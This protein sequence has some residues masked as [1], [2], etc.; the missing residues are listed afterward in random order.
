[1]VALTITL[2]CRCRACRF[3]EIPSLHQ[4]CIFRTPA[5]YMAIGGQKGS[6]RDDRKWPVDL[7]FWLSFYHAGLKIGKVPRTL[8]YWRQRPGQQ[9]RSHGRLS[10]SNMRKCKCEFLCMDGGPIWPEVS[11]ESVTIEIWSTGQT[12]DGWVDDLS[13]ELKCQGK[14]AVVVPVHWRPGQARPLAVE[15]GGVHQRRV[16]LFAFGMEKVRRQ[17]REIFA[18]DWNDVDCIFVA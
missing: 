1:M 7:H 6:Y 14:E 15:G 10:V 4:A 11:S 17:V 8:F 5:V 3:I 16:R 18:S 12:L 13:F 2:Y 9:T